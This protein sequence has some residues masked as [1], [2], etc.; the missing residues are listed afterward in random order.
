MPKAEIK[1]YIQASKNLPE[2]TYV[3]LSETFGDEIGP[4]DSG[5]PLEF[6]GI[7]P[8]EWHIV[9]M[10]FTVNP[11]S[12]IGRLFTLTGS[13]MELT[14]TTVSRAILLEQHQ[15]D[16]PTGKYV[17]I[18]Y[19]DTPQGFGDWTAYPIE[20]IHK[21]WP[22]GVIFPY[23][24]LPEVINHPDNRILAVYVDDL[25]RARGGNPHYRGEKPLRIHRTNLP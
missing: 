9:K 21:N 23:G 17:Y 12:A 2:V 22:E 25:V 6:L 10:L 4:H 3:P 24:S 19:S 15:Q 5:D 16:V 8:D 7:D 18:L 14:D 11:E 13:Q 1:S 20:E